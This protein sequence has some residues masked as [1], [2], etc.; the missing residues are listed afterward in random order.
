MPKNLEF[1][2]F[3]D[4]KYNGTAVNDSQRLTLG[5]Q[6]RKLAMFVIFQITIHF[7]LIINGQKILI[8]L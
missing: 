8:M 1:N 4:I 5:I 3:I 2:F 6:W 7:T